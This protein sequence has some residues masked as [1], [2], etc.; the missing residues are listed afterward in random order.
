ML[1]ALLLA[2]ALSGALAAPAA[3]QTAATEYVVPATRCYASSDFAI[4]TTDGGQAVRVAGAFLTPAGG[5]VRPTVVMITGSGGHL[6]QQMIS[7]VPM[8]GL[9]ADILARAG[10]NVVMADSRGFGGSTVDGQVWEEDKWLQVPTS[11]RVHDN[12]ALLDHVLTLPQVKRDGLIVLG[13]SEGSMIAGVLAAN[14]TDIALSVLLAD[15]TAPGN[16]LF[17]DQRT[18]TAVRRGATPEMAAAIRVQLLAMSAQFVK[19]PTDDAAFE[20]IKQGFAEAQKGLE[21]PIYGPGFVDFHRTAPFL[22]HLMTYDPWG[23]I[24]RIKSPVLAIWG[25]NDDATPAHVHAPILMRALGQADNDDVALHV[26]PD[27]DH[28]FLEY[29]GKRIARHPYGR[30][31]VSNELQALL[32][33]ELNQRFPASQP[34]CE[35]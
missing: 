2:T 21:Q 10:F 18:Q 11:L 9:L 12:M 30:T 14:R 8:F 25:G 23:D 17:A 27:Q 20:A 6:R 34:Y 13:H 29:E 35:G 1:K 32:L 19:D 33:S 24:S 7:G 5:G 26:I 31:R 22:I 16:E 15:S 3:A 4:D 28:F